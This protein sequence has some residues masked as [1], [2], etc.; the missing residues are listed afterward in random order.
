[1]RRLSTQVLDALAL[2]HALGVLRGSAR[3]RYLRYVR[4]DAC[5]AQAHRDWR[6]RALRLLGAV[7][8]CTPPP[9]LLAT[10]RRRLQKCARADG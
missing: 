9:S 8:P 3:R 6:H 1:M 7:A 4:T 2:D 5:V 10:V